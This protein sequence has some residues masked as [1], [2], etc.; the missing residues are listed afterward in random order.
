MAS[1]DDPDEVAANGLGATA[2]AR[3]PVPERAER[4]RRETVQKGRAAGVGVNTP[5]G[6]PF[7]AARGVA[8]PDHVSGD[9]FGGEAILPGLPARDLAPRPH[10]LAGA[11]PAWGAHH[12]RAP[13]RGRGSADGDAEADPDRPE[14][15]LSPRGACAHDQPRGAVLHGKPDQGDPQL[16]LQDD[17]PHQAHP[18]REPDREAPGGD[19]AAHEPHG[20]RPDVQ[21]AHLPPGRDRQ[22]PE[23]RLP[24]DG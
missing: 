15:R 18:H 16:H 12:E 17:L 4:L 2:L 3:T 13:G 19:R 1:S 24:G 9:R 23:T 6:L 20:P 10:H 5:S 22:P 14:D 11:A 21:Q 8:G 7:R